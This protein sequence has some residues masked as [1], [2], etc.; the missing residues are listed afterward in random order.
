MEILILTLWWKTIQ[1]KIH[2]NINNKLM[3]KVWAQISSWIHELIL[4]TFTILCSAGPTHPPPSSARSAGGPLSEGGSQGGNAKPR[5]RRKESRR[6]RQPQSGRGRVYWG[7]WETWPTFCTAQLNQSLG[8][9]Y[10]QTEH[11]QIHPPPP[12]IC[13]SQGQK[14]YPKC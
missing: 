14:N 4:K 13:T 5:K 3:G 9:P 7:R 12:I 1:M 2:S 10:F 11:R 8:V 6:R